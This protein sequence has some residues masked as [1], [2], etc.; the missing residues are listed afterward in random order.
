MDLDYFTA[1]GSKYLTQP[2]A[3]LPLDKEVLS[4]DTKNHGLFML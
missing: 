1:D 3:L 4:S 2:P